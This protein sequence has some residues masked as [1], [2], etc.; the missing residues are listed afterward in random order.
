MNVSC[1]S[2]GRQIL[3]PPTSGWRERSQAGPPLLAS[4]LPLQ[5][6]SGIE[7]SATAALVWPR[8]ADGFSRRGAL[9]RSLK[10][11]GCKLPQVDRVLDTG[12]A[13]QDGVQP[14]GGSSWVSGRRDLWASTREERVRWANSQVGNLSSEGWWLGGTGRAQ[15]EDSPQRWQLS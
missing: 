4:P 3:A 15:G 6:L 13:G 2:C 8:E 9:H 10:W 5:H 7:S 12:P 11:T 14:L 1:F